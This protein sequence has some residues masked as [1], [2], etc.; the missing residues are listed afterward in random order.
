MRESTVNGDQITACPGHKSIPVMLCAHAAYR[1]IGRRQ[2]RDGSGKAVSLSLCDIRAVINWVGD[3]TEQRHCRKSGR[4]LNK[5]L[6]RV[7][8]RFPGK[9]MAEVWTAERSRGKHSQWQQK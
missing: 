1:C 9:N 2:R 7:I 4:R 8:E 6:R 5:S 3:N